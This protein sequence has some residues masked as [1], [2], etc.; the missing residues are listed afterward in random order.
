MPEKRDGF[1]AHAGYSALGRHHQ[2]IRHSHTSPFK[3]MFSRRRITCSVVKIAGVVNK[4]FMRSAVYNGRMLS[5]P[6]HPEVR[7]TD[8]QSL[9]WLLATKRKPKPGDMPQSDDAP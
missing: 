5:Y 4:K 2:F 6:G 1:S 8:V 7:R 3:T 9:Q